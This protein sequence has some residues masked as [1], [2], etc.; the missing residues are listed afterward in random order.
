MQVFVEVAKMTIEHGASL[1]KD[2]KMTV[3][4]SCSHAKGAKMTI[5]DGSSH[6][7]MMTIEHGSLVMPRKLPLSIACVMPRVQR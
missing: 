7:D 1:A 2:S 3:E 5:E 6:T 4:Q